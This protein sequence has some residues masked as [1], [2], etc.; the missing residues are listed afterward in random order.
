MLGVAYKRDINDVRESPA[1]GIA[2]QL[3]DKGADLCYH[4]PFI[5]EMRLDGKGTLKNTELTD[6]ILRQCDC[7]LVVTDHS[8][9]DYEKVV[10]LAPLIIDTRNATRKLDVA[11][12]EAK[13]IRL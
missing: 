12:H 5:P 6:E 4:D 10:T 3:L 9:L 13:I 11:E 1:L 7:V 8:A 2:E